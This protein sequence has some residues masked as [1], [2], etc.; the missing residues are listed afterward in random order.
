VAQT[1]TATESL[2]AKNFAV[3]D[4]LVEETDVISVIARPD[5]RIVSPGIWRRSGIE[6][7]GDFDRW[8]APFSMVMIREV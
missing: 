7:A 2:L 8:I 4:F 3:F 1:K 5:G 6:G